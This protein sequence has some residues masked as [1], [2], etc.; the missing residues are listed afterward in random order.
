MMLGITRIV[1]VDD[2]GA[3]L[4][5]LI[6]GLNH[7]GAACLGVQYTGD[8]DAMGLVACPHA[9]MVF[10]DVNLPG[11]PSS[12]SPEQWFAIIGALL[13]RI[14][15]AGPYLLVIWTRLSEQA[16]ELRSFLDE[17]LTDIAKPFAILP[18]P[19]ERYIDESGG[20]TNLN[21]L[22]QAIRDFTETVPALA[23][24]SEWE[25]KVSSAAAETL[26][27][28]ITLG[29]PGKTSEEQQNDLARITV[30]MAVEAVGQQNVGANPF[31][32]VNEA[33]LPVMADLVA[34]T[35]VDSISKD[36]WQQV[37]NNSGAT[38]NISASEAALLNRVF[39]IAEDTGTDQGAERGA[40]IPL[41]CGM[42][43]DQFVPTFGIPENDAAE[44]L[45]RCQNFQPGSE[46]S[47]WVL[48]QA[49]AACDYAQRRP[50]PLPFF[51]GMDVAES[52]LSSNRAPQALWRS[53]AFDLGG[54]VRQLQVNTRVQIPLSGEAARS[55]E[56]MYRLREQL[57]GELLHH[58][59]TN[60]A[61]PGIVSF[62]R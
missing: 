22:I 32:A 4:D 18:L 56:P 31:R 46:H 16:A 54:S 14:K 53:P 60:N 1:A 34:S 35:Q 47:R 41:P 33:L 23:A 24:L 27:S 49:Q 3:D 40:V 55:H 6:T 20:V 50:G 42:S 30:A 45:F 28:V 37:I 25:E 59:Q 17:R 44:R 9:R 39:H 57:L 61:R 11:G 13:S 43:G 62:N 38:N 48:V 51:L 36:V 26:T 15:P 5:A 52:N 12:S 10:M 58:A 19:K 29:T 7:A 8:L 21:G 2:S